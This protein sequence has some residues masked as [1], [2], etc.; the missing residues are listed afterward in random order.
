MNQ[1][2]TIV[3][4]AVSLI[5]ASSGFWAFMQSRSLRRNETDRL[6]MGLAYDRIIA[7]GF[8]YIHRGWITDDEY[9]DYRTLLYEPYKKLGG[10][11]V[12][13]RIMA[14]V[15]NL[16]IR[17]RAM[18]ATIL[19][20]AKTRSPNYDQPLSDSDTRVLVEQ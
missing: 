1:F 12:T 20:E 15:A 11:G 7:M 14:E 13:E 2:W 5:I 18:Y 10:N 19:Q 9:N 3:I 6:L 4:P 17:S 16:P 8:G